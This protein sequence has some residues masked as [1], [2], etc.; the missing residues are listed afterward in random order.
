M[1][2]V[3]TVYYTSVKQYHYFI[4]NQNKKLIGLES[5][6]EIQKCKMLPPPPP[7]LSDPAKSRQRNVV[8]YVF[9]SVFIWTQKS[10]A[11]FS[12]SFFTV[13]MQ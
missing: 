12:K 2:D 4:N 11:F 5:T 9:K 10:V 8:A 13:R 7:P 6:G 3:F 1:H